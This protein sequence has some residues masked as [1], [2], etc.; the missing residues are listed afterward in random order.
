MCDLCDECVSAPNCGHCA[1]TTTRY[2]CWLSQHVFLSSIA[3]YLQ[4]HVT[5][6]FL[7]LW[8]LIWSK[9]WDMVSTEEQAHI[10][11]ECLFS[12]T[13]DL[14]LAGLFVIIRLRATDVRCFLMH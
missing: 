10:A 5:A 8:G 3:H 11:R 12:L 7:L 1:L 4:G 14:F 9:H 2:V 13:S 6:S